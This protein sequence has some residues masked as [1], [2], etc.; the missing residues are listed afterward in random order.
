MAFQ[1]GSTPYI[2]ANHSLPCRERTHLLHVLVG[3]IY[4]TLNAKE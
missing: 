4:K 3:E 1:M 2:Q